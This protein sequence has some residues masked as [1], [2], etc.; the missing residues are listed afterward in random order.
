[1]QIGTSEQMVCPLAEQARDQTLCL[2]RSRN[3]V[4]SQVSIASSAS[5][6]LSLDSE[7]VKDGAEDMEDR[8]GD[9]VFVM[10]F[11]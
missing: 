6:L 3:W 2:A 8:S 5:L 4:C 9:Q 10:S 1:M 11:F 7:E